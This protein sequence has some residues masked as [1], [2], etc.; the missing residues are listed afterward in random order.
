MLFNN[1]SDINNRDEIT[2]FEDTWRWDELLHQKFYDIPPHVSCMISSLHNFIGPNSLMAYLVYMTIRLAELHR[3]LKSTGS[4]YLHCDPTA[5]HYLRII[6]DTI[7]GSENFKNEIIWKR[8][9]AHN[10][11]KKQFGAI[12]DHIL[13]YS[14]SKETLFNRQF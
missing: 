13:F 12:S 14:R 4:L 11:A 9:D 10:D 1:K 2:V 8:S 6:L 7:F 3:V 5:S